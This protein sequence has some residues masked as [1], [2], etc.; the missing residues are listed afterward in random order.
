ML[1]SFYSP[2]LPPRQ[3]RA[4]ARYTEPAHHTS[5]ILLNNTSKPN[6]IGSHQHTHSLSY[7]ESPNTN[8]T[9]GSYNQREHVWLGFVELDET[10]NAGASQGLDGG[11][12][13][14]PRDAYVGVGGCVCP[15]VC[16]FPVGLGAVDLCGGVECL[17]SPLASLSHAQTLTRTRPSAPTATRASP[18]PSSCAAGGT[19]TPRGRARDSCTSADGGGSC[20]SCFFVHTHALCSNAVIV[21]GFGRK[22]VWMCR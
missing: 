8:P 11:D 2:G 6:Q 19:C 5:I 7:T 9:I 10:V 4:S 12:E 17:L 22:C 20:E 14:L 16:V 21:G 15:L 13:L 3:K 18:R 1:C